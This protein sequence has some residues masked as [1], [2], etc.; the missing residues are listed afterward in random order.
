[1]RAGSVALIPSCAECTAVW[2]PAD[3]ERWQALPT[4]DEPPE[5]V[6]YCPECAEREFGPDQCARA[7]SSVTASRP[8]QS[9][10]SARSPSPPGSRGPARSRSA[11]DR[12]AGPRQPR[13]SARGCLLYTSDAA[14]ERSSVDL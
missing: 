1:M 5:I 8:G 9:S 11:V 12:S 10:R 7:A 4:D 2:L 14:D 13:A 3:E 6:L